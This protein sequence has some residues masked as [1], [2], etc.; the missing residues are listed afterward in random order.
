MRILLCAFFLFVSALAFAQDSSNYSTTEL[1]YGRKDGLA[2]TMLKLSPKQHSNGKAIIS[3]LSGNWVSGYSM[4]AT[5]IRRS[6]TYIS[7][8]YTVFLVMH[9]SQPR[10]AIPDE[11]SDVK[12]AIR[13]IRY[14]ATAYAIDSSHIGITGSSSGGHLSLMAALSDDKINTSAADPVDRVSSRVQAAA[15]FFPPTDFLNWG[16]AN[17]G[18]NKQMIIRARVAGAFDFKQKNNAT[19]VFETITNDSINLATAKVIS[20]IYSVSSDDPPV[21]IIHGDADPV[22]PLQQSQSIIQK[23]KEASVPNEFII[24]PGGSHGWRDMEVEE[25][26]FVSWFDKWLR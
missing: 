10:Y 16:A 3:L 8:G 17:T 25:K 26:K 13:F 11:I 19:G 22:V 20:P 23:L 7:N 2:L 1:I 9:G 6:A 14:N 12:R 4:T 21:M 18:V 5:G 15:V 24:K